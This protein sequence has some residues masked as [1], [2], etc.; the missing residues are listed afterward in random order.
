MVKKI[1]TYLNKEKRELLLALASMV[2]ITIVFLLY[3]YL[4]GV[5]MT[6]SKNFF[7]LAVYELNIGDK[8]KAIESLH[9]S[10]KFQYTDDAQNLLNEIER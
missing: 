3:L 9:N 2:A 8:K 1:Q 4:V 10:L 7:N 5:P 6:R